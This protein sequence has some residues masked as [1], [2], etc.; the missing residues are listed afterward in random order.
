MT[1]PSSVFCNANLG[2]DERMVPNFSM[3][4]NMH[5]AYVSRKGEPVPVSIYTA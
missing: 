5:C 4:P 3:I 1:V 2:K